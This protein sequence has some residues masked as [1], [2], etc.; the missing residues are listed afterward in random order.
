[1]AHSFVFEKKCIKNIYDNMYN[2][3]N[4]FSAEP[5]TKRL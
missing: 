1:M 2:P 5:K 3:Q 4:D